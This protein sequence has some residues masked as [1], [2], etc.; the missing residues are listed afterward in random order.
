M[1]LLCDAITYRSRSRIA[2][3]QR[4][5]SHSHV[6]STD[7]AVGTYLLTSKGRRL[8]NCN[9]PA[10]ERLIIPTLAYY[11][12]TDSRELS[13]NIS[14]SL[15]LCAARWLDEITI[16]RVL[17]LSTTRSRMSLAHVHRRLRRFALSLTGGR[18]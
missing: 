3:C 15:A 1:S 14:H 11:S 5:A 6:V 17:M 18:Q 7:Y 2:R 9:V 8:R 13:H 12:L 16:T 4:C 10:H